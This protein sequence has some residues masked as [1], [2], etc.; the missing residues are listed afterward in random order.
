MKTVATIIL[1]LAGAAAVIFGGYLLWILLS[2]FLATPGSTAIHYSSKQIDILTDTAK[3]LIPTV[4]GFAVL[5]AS[6][7]GYLYTHGHM[8]SEPL[9]FGVFSVFI[10][11]VFSMAC[12]IYMLGAMVDCSHPFGRI[13]DKALSPDV[14]VKNAAYLQHA[15]AVAVTCAKLACVSFFVALDGALLIALRVFSDHRHRPNR[16]K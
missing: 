16:M 9:K 11:I 15:Y 2:L 7:L 4:A 3:A 6:G 5:A 12:W 14:T 13:Q 10:A 1:S 8:R